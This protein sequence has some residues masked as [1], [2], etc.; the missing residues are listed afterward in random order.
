MPYRACTPVL[1][2]TLL[3]GLLAAV[4]SGLGGCR[5]RWSPLPTA[6]E[7]AGTVALPHRDAS[8]SLWRG[9]ALVVTECGDCHRLFWPYEYPPNAWPGMV[10]RMARKT[11]W[12]GQQIHDMTVYLVAA[13]RAT[14]GESEA[15][16]LQA[17]LTLEP[18]P[19]AIARGRSL[20]VAHCASCHRFYQPRE[21]PPEAWPGIVRS[22]AELTP[23]TADELLDIARYYVDAARRSQ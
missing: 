18:D 17:A 2:A 15:D 22:M 8:E 20:A 21:Y 7:L 12:T 4:G 3:G 23:V 5:A 6:E 9:R 11:P 19:E 10:A 13:S 1:A 14:G 16:S